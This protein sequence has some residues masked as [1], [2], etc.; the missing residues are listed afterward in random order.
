MH[1]R[2]PSHTHNSLSAQQDKW[3]GRGEAGGETPRPILLTDGFRFGAA[4]CMLPLR[5]FCVSSLLL[6]L[7]RQPALACTGEIEDAR[8]SLPRVAPRSP[9][10]SLTLARLLFSAVLAL[11]VLLL[12]KLARL[13]LDEVPHAGLYGSA[14]FTSIRLS[15]LRSRT[16]SP[17]MRCLREES[18]L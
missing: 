4:A 12:D 5:G 9:S 6:L 7:A 18:S 17:L 14:I 2:I 10:P 16:S 15:S 3:F 1:M 13:A 11:S 8:P